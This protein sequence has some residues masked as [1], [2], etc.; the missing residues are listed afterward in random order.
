MELSAL[1]EHLYMCKVSQGRLFG[2][3]CAA[4]WMNGFVAA[5]LVTTLVVVALLIG[6]VSLVL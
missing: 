2:L 1:G 3:H 6:L 5:R 4:E